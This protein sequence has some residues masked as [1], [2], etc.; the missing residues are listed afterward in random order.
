L[1]HL[2][3]YHHHSTPTQQSHHHQSN[4]IA[5]TFPWLTAAAAAQQIQ[6]STNNFLESFTSSALACGY[7]SIIPH[8]YATPNEM[9]NDNAKL[10]YYHNFH[11]K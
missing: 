11:N 6:S 10:L 9:S 3:L 5:A 4:Y 1:V 8:S 7:N 2:C